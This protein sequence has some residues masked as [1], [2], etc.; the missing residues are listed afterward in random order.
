MPK[1]L[2][3]RTWL[4]SAEAAPA[5]A[6]SRAAASASALGVRDEVKTLPLSDVS[7]RASGARPQRSITA[8]SGRL[9]LP[10]ERFG[11][12]GQHAGVHA[13]RREG[14]AELDAALGEGVV[15]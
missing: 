2:E 1:P 14:C 11:A 8:G 7:G 15:R 13:H 9:E 5:P 4:T 3:I 6:S 10:G 12:A